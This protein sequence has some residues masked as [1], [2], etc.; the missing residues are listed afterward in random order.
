MLEIINN[1]R[2]FFEDCYREIGVREYAKIVQI[3]PPTASA[4]LKNFETEGLL[5]KREYRNLILFRVNRESLI[6][7]DLSRIYWRVKL[8]MLIKKLNE[9]LQI[10][11]LVLFG[12]L[13]K[14]ETKP[15]SDIDLALI[16]NSKNIIN[17][18]GYEKEFGR[19]IEVFR[20]K[21]LKDIKNKELEM[22]I[23]NG[24]A[25]DGEI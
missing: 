4:L 10:H 16:S 8:K 18:E 20:F 3:S 11:V 9:K 23:L 14:L 6:L 2:P 19:K 5:K 15:D 25:L 21:S 24:C 13:S 7:R 22:N 12:S 1:L 17:L